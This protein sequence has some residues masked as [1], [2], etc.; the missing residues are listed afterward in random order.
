MS[1]GNLL[2]LAAGLICGIGLSMGWL[3]AY[4]RRWLYGKDDVLRDEIQS[5]KYNS[6]V[7][8]GLGM[9]AFLVFVSMGAAGSKDPSIVKY[10]LQPLLLPLGFSVY[11]P[12]LYWKRHLIERL[13]CVNP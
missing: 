13:K 10:G 2:V 9:W 8:A 3:L 7:K 4:V 12:L 1:I 11:F 6:W 5:F